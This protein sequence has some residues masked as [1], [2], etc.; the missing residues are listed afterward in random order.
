M[1]QAI[2][3]AILLFSQQQLA[4]KFVI[5]LDH[6]APSASTD[7][8]KA[9]DQYFQNR[10]L[11]G[12][13]ESTHGTHEFFV[14][15][16][17]LIR[18]LVEN[19]QFNRVFMEADFANCLAVNDYISGKGG[20][21][22]EAVDNLA[23]WPWE[24][25][26]FVELV[27]WLKLYNQS[28]PSNSVEFVGVDVQK[29][30]ETVRRLEMLLAKYDLPG[31]EDEMIDAT[32][33]YKLGGKEILEMRSVEVAR[34][35]GVDVSSFSSQDTYEY[36]WLFRHLDQILSEKSEKKSKQN[37]YRDKMMAENILEH[38]KEGSKKKGVF[39]AHN[40]HVAN[41]F[42]KKKDKGVA[43]GYLKK[44]LGAEYFILGQEFD[45]GSFNARTKPAE[46]SKDYN[47]WK[48][49]EV[50]VEESPEGSVAAYYRSNNHPIMFIP[51]DR[52]PE[53]LT[54]YMNFIGAVYWTNKKGEAPE[55]LRRNN[56]GREA[57]DA[58]ILF[59]E[60]TPTKLLK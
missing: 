25:E 6:Y 7:D 54:V 43:G 26:E 2:L 14:M 59:Q 28:H 35:E 49:M 58:I 45:Y 38:L 34:Y 57:F 10:Q 50:E 16:H 36:K 51:F 22:A 47:E 18:Y 40:G 48:L 23:L 8:L 13:G 4:Q 44:T 29:I 41:L 9:L 42:N 21:A 30:G 37:G 55:Y 56:H 52:L 24:T 5:K 1:K 32:A 27:E 60:S 39:W 19:H 3:L 17:R 15:R 12:L 31:R 11:V 33:F 46:Y 20:T 53:E